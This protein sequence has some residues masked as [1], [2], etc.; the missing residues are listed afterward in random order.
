MRGVTNSPDLSY[1]TELWRN[2]L[3]SNFEYL[4]QLNHFAGRS[5]NDLTQYP[6]FPFVLVG[7][8]PSSREEER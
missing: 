1:V 8:A 6:V 5:F 3:I 2:R 4:M 7:M